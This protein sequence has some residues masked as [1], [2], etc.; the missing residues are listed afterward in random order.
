MSDI[1]TKAIRLQA[2]R[3]H[4]REHSVPLYLTSSFTYES[5]EQARAVFAD[6]EPGNIYSRFSNPNVDELVEKMCYLEKAEDGFAFA[7]GMSAVFT[8]MA[9][10]LSA[11][12]HV[13]A[14]RAVFGS[15]HQL[16]TSILPRWGITHSYA[17]ANKPEDWEA[18]ITPQTKMILVETP[19]N[20]GLELID[21]EFLGELKRKHNLL[22]VV[23]NCF[24]TPILQTPI[25][26]G[27]DLV[28]HSATKYIDG[29]GRV[30]GGMVVGKAE[31]I[32]EIRFFSRHTG[33]A[34][35][36]F[37]AWVLSKSLET[38]SLRI[39]KHCE[40]A[41]KLAQTLEGNPALEVVNYP[42][43]PS[44]PQYELAKKQM[45]QGG[46][47]VTFVVKGGYEAA[48]RFIDSLKLATITSNLGD[49]RTIVTHPA[50]TTHSKL[51]AEE[52]AATGISEGLIRVS[53]G[54]ESLQDIIE[55]IEQALAKV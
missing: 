37:N 20:P 38:L 14:G 55:D 44:Y 45:K 35:S 36:P 46:G 49:T 22:L 43:L 15:T 8:S 31:L 1:E 54:L 16:L 26:F 47:I 24:A 50:S 34:L 29:Q 11:G 53:V 2:K 23:D 13:L 40:N 7:T 25:D 27:A 21:L 32:K 17:D 6:E 12:D 10:L 5:A 19:S 33:P 42:F 51:S 28:V 48:T 3:S 41:L 9:S 52:K 30:L 18:L 39:D 4:N